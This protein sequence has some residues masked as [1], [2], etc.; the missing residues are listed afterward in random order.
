MN[1]LGEDMYKRNG[2]RDPLEVGRYI[3]PGSEGA[4]LLPVGDFLSICKGVKSWEIAWHA[5]LKL[6]F[7]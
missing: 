7:T 2:F 6:S 5:E 4:P 1:A 3:D